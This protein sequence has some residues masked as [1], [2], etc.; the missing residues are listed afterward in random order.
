MKIAK[1]LSITV[2]FL[3]VLAL[4]GSASAKRAGAARTA[5]NEAQQGANAIQETT[6]AP[7]REGRRQSR[8]PLHG[9]GGEGC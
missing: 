8:P 3:M 6:E 2:A 9:R 1:L 5:N 7:D 4:G